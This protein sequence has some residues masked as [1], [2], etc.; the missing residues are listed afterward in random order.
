MLIDYLFKFTV[1]HRLE[2]L[3]DAANVAERKALERVGFQ[4]EG[5]LR[6]VAFRHGSW[7]DAVIYALLR[8]GP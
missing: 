7:R 8:D 3:T 4:R 2:A 6:E 5:V 1:A